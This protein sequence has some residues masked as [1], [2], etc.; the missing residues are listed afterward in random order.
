MSGITVS[1]RHD[2]V[3]AVK[4]A[5][6]ESDDAARLLVEAEVLQRISHPGAVEYVDHQSEPTVQLVTMCAGTDPCDRQPP[7]GADITSALAA[8]V[9]VVADLHD[10]KIAHGG[11]ITAHIINGPDRRPVLCGFG[12]ATPLSAESEAADLNALATLLDGLTADVDDEHQPGV[13]TVSAELRQGSITARVATA[14]LDA[15]HASDTPLAPA[16][17]GSRRVLAAAAVGVLAIAI[18]ATAGSRSGPMISAAPSTTAAV[19]TTTPHTTAPASTALPVPSPGAPTLINQGRLYALGRPGDL[20]VVGDWNCDGT[21]TPALLRP[22]TGEVAVFSEWPE[23][24]AGIA[25]QH[26]VV[27]AGARSLEIDDQAPCIVL[28]VR[29]ANG[30]VLIPLE[31]T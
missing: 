22:A 12:R 2:R 17:Q 5:A 6:I 1:R 7:R 10:A 25:A 27:V 15:L 20:A 4:E 11:L 18:A 19:T 14:R 28:R 29:T 30:S 23:P 31:S 21:E 9:S 24:K 13:A 8:V 3:V 16:R 26:I